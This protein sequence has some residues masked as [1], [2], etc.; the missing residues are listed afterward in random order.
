MTSHSIVASLADALTR[1]R[2]QLAC[3]ESCTGG[4]IAAWLTDRPGSSAW[5]ERGVVTYT[6][7]A[8][9][10][11]LGVPDDVFREH[12]AVSAACVAA[13]ASGLLQ[14]APVDWT[15]SVSGIAGPS[16]GSPD[17]PVGTVW[18]GWAGRGLAAET[19]CRHF[20]GDRQ[21]VREAAALHALTGLLQRI[22][23]AAG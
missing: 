4:L 13:M 16:G 22:D 12:G 10:E 23:R 6:N 17:K 1:R 9:S 21:A 3:A 19:E 20:D 11:L 15:L 7:T 8:K 5:F 18:F 2:Q 14:R